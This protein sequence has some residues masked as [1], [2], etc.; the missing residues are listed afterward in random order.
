MSLIDSR[1]KFQAEI[2]DMHDPAL[3]SILTSQ[4]FQLFAISV[5]SV[6]SNQDTQTKKSIPRAGLPRL[7]YGLIA[8]QDRAQQVR[9]RQQPTG[10][11]GNANYLAAPGLLHNGIELPLFAKLQRLRVDIF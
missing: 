7:A 3:S 8:R 10:I 11:Y 4:C 2:C 5:I 9:P 6:P 1:A